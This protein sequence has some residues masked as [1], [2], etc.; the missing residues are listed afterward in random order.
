M[1]VWDGLEAEARL[2]SMSDAVAGVG[3]PLVPRQALLEP[4]GCAEDDALRY[5][6]LVTG[7]MLKSSEDGL[8][9]LVMA[10][11]RLR[12]TLMRN[13]EAIDCSDIPARVAH[14]ALLRLAFVA[15]ADELI[16][17]AEADMR[18]DADAADFKL[19]R[20]ISLFRSLDKSL[21]KLEPR[22]KEAASACGG[23]ARELE[24]VARVRAEVVSRKAD[25]KARMS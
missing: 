1:V 2:K 21:D 12:T 7:A 9:E 23:L 24:W 14:T 19:I 20:A 18:V 3:E 15:R 22:I 8:N 13:S 16:T 25:A 4:W 5:G 6:A 17:E 10:W 11:Q